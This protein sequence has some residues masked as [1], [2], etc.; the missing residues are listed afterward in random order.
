M[1]SREVEIL[2]QLVAR[3]M[4]AAYWQLSRRKILQH[5][6]PLIHGVFNLWQPGKHQFSTSTNQR[7]SASIFFSPYK[8]KY[9]YVT[10]NITADPVQMMLS[11][12]K[13]ATIYFVFWR[14]ETAALFG[15]VISS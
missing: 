10:Q 1:A 5:K 7:T 13:K 14:E 6:I 8:V 4:H 12:L 11:K 15:L 2:Q 9:L 3:K